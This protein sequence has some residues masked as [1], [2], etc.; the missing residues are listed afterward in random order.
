[1]VFSPNLLLHLN[2]LHILPGLCLIPVQ[3]LGMVFTVVFEDLVKIWKQFGA[4]IFKTVLYFAT[5]CYDRQLGIVFLLQYDAKTFSCIY[6]E[7]KDFPWSSMVFPK[8]SQ[9]EQGAKCN[10]PGSWATKW[11]RCQT[12]QTNPPERSLVQ[13][14]CPFVATGFRHEWCN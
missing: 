12:L 7:M 6:I 14:S 8:L 10:A 13:S 4:Q 5:S 9:P 3:L 11:C 1:M 2:T